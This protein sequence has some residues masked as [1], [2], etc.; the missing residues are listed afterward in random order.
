MD[1]DQQRE[2]KFDTLLE[3]YRNMSESD[4]SCVLSMVQHPTSQQMISVG[5]RHHSF[6]EELSKLGW[7]TSAELTPELKNIGTAYLW[8]ITD[9]GVIKLP[10]LL[11]ALTTTGLRQNYEKI[12]WL[13]SAKFCLKLSIALLLFQP[14]VLAAGYAIGKSEI[15]ISG[16]QGYFS[17]AIV[18][19]SFLL[20][21]NFASKIWFQKS[22]SEARVANISHFEFLGSN[23][24]VISFLAAIT[25]VLIHIMVLFV[26][27]HFGWGEDEK[28]VNK[29]VFQSAF[30]GIVFVWM[31]MI[32]LPRIIQIKHDK[33]FRTRKRKSGFA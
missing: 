20:S 7:A 5:T 17:F 28:F 22:A 29:Y 23:T 10:T 31:S 6:F 27:T 32:F 26:M 12:W 21:L 13:E 3:H 18:C 30:L 11:L 15:N 14:L 19:L 8:Q 2:G 25:A 1:S 4:K 33:Q 24:T 9:T 16:F